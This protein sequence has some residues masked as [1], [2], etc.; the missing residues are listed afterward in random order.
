MSCLEEYQFDYFNEYPSNCV[1]EGYFNDKEN[2]KLIK[3]DFLNSKF[4]INSINNKKICFK[5][6]YSCPENYPYLDDITHECKSPP[7][8]IPF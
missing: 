4:Y 3:C 8:V 2:E 6:I 5:Y 7:T 1:P